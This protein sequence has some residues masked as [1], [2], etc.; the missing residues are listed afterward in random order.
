MALSFS[1]KVVVITGA[2]SG[3]GAGLAKYFAAR[4]AK[5]ALAAR[6]VEGLS[7]VAAEIG[8]DSKVLIVKTDVTKRRDHEAL[9][10]ATL[11]KFGKVSVW[12]NNA[13][14][15]VPKTFEQLE[16]EDLDSMISV[17]TKSVLFG[18]QAAIKHFKQYSVSADTEGVVINV[19][20][21]LG[22]VP[23]YSGLAAYK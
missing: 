23:M 3:I 15:V 5:V 20:S 9:L 16:E 14:A 7:A 2:S 18:T 10:A 4:G 13:G 17:N 1:N 8:D 19:S 22:R 11:K 21:V 12:I 6:S